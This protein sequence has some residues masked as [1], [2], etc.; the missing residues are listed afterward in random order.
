MFIYQP[1]KEIPPQNFKLTMKASVGVKFFGATESILEV[2][3]NRNIFYPGDMI[4]IYL[5]CD[6]TACNKDVRSYKFKLHRLMRSKLAKTGKYDEFVTN[7]KTTK[8]K[9][10]KASTREKKHLQFQIPLMEKDC[11]DEATNLVDRTSRAVMNK[12]TRAN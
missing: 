3:F 7:L 12:D 1:P 9:G 2:R 6:N 11:S 10:C 4:D 8:E 5:D